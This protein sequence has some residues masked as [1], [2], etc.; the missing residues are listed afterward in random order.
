MT[1]IYVTR[2]YL[3]RLAVEANKMNEP[4]LRTMMRLELKEL[5]ERSANGEV[6]ICEDLPE[7]KKNAIDSKIVIKVEQ[8]ETG[9][10]LTFAKLKEASWHV[11]CSVYMITKHAK[12]GKPIN[13]FTIEI[14]SHK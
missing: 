1:K 4:Y 3:N 12:T 10:I 14:K 2:H 7:W 8:I 9:K 5:N 13:G 11:G 6:K